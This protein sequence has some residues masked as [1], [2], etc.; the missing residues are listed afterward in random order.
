V[1]LC[2]VCQK[3]IATIDPR[4]NAQ[5]SFTYIDI[6]SIDPTN[7]TISNP[8]SIIGKDAPKRARRLVRSRDVLVST[9]RP[10][11]NAVAMAADEHNG[12]V[13][14][15]AICVLRP[16]AEVLPEYL[17]WFV[18]SPEFVDSLSGQATGAVYLSVSDRQV[19][20]QWIPLPP[21]SEQRRI[22]AVLNDRMAA[23]EKARTA[24]EKQ[25]E[26]A[27]ELPS[28]YLDEV[29]NSENVRNW[30]RSKLGDICR[31]ISDGN[32]FTPHYVQ[33]GVPFLL[34]KNVCEQALSFDDCRYVSGEEH[35]QLCRRCKPEMGDVLYTKVGVIGVAKAVAT[36]REFSVGV[37]VAVLKLLPSILPGY[38]EMMLNSQ[39]CRNQAE[40]LVR[41]SY[42]SNLA[43]R[44]LKQIVVVVPPV[45]EQQRLVEDAKSRISPY[46]NLLS[47]LEAQL[48]TI[49][50]LGE[51][52]LSSAFRGEL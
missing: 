27:R 34:A 36:D 6:S 35:Q 45:S 8:K 1:Q 52:I 22:T 32:H 19:R 26:A 20:D 13:C 42:Y 2:D 10:K 40:R 51:T 24:C 50:E 21:L 48:A 28:V 5:S 16:K 31:E 17:Y 14:S 4:T 18:R 49:N 29:F 7:K 3:K 33:S 11:L 46:H 38:L 37:S 43:I 23:V 25:L 30:E 39:F 15:T 12:Y 9:V 44:E 47:S 41:C